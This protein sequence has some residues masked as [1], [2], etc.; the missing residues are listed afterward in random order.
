MRDNCKIFVEQ[1]CNV[2]EVPEPVFEFGS[3]QVKN[4]EGY[5]N[6]RPFFKRKKYVGLDMQHGPGVDLAGDIMNLPLKDESI[7]TVL[8]IETLEH[9]KNPFLATRE[10]YRVLRKD[11]VALITTP[12]YFKIHSYPYDYWRMT[13]EAYNALL[14]R[15]A[16]RFI[17]SQGERKRPH[18][19]FAI[20]VKS[21][22][23]SWDNKI[24]DL[25]KVLNDELGKGPKEGLWR[26][27][28]LAIRGYKKQKDINF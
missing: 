6:L 5:A 28:K 4:Q 7:G 14:E 15:Y 17:F 26:L 24:S 10:I 11:G 2:F 23:D 1:V 8:A 20:A 18:T 22:S 25:K 12:M 21:D 13:P 3:L 27:V 9:V 16:K 19:V